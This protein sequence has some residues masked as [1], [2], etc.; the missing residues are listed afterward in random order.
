MSIEETTFDTLTAAE[1]MRDSG[2]DERLAT[3]IVKMVAGAQQALV[4]RAYFDA[5][6]TGIDSRFTVLEQR[7]ATLEQ[8][9]AALDEKFT[10]KFELLEQKVD[11]R[12][13]RLES[14]LLRKFGAMF[15]AGIGFL[16]VLIKFF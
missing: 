7:I 13:S 2:V 14:D 16:A 6:M 8:R 10:L 9:I 11:L 12:I 5:R 3:V 15:V 1:E 4:T